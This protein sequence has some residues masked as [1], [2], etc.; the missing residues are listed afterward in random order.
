[1]HI[2]Q[3]G[4]DRASPGRLY[5]VLV[6][7]LLWA[8]PVLAS[9]EG[10]G[11]AIFVIG[12]VTLVPASGPP[13]VL[14]KGHI[15]HVGDRIDT[16]DKGQV[17]IRMIDGAFIAV[18]P[19]S[20]FVVKRYKMD[21]DPQKSESQFELIKGGF[22]AITGKIGKTNKKSYKVVTP[23]AT[24]GIRG[25]DYVAMYCDQDCDQRDHRE[26]KEVVRDGLY[27]G[28]V[29]G[30]IHV[31]N[32]VATIDVHRSQYAYIENRR[33]EPRHL[34]QMPSFLM[35]Q[36]ESPE[37][38]DLA[39]Y[40]HRNEASL[41]DEEEHEH[42]HVAMGREHNRDENIYDHYWEYV[43]G[44]SLSQQHF[45]TRDNF[46]YAL[47]NSTSISFE[48]V[49]LGDMQVRLADLGG[50][51]GVV[52]LL[53]TGTASEYDLGTDP[54]TGLTWGRWAGGTVVVYD[55]VTGEISSVDLG[56]DSLHWIA[57]GDPGELIVLPTT[58]T[59][60]YVL[61]GNTSP[62]DNHG[63][64]GN[65]ADV[66]A[67]LAADFTAQTMDAQ[68]SV[69]INNQVWTATGTGMAI[70]TVNATFAG[71]LNVDVTDS[72]TMNTAI[73]SGTMNGAF[74]G[75]SPTGGAP[76]NVGAAYSMNSDI[77]GVA[78]TVSGVGAFELA[79]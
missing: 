74:S 26:N 67:S 31:T 70:D 49:P 77:N 2:L 71:G 78:T 35:F 51:T 27:V 66:S 4:K 79:P 46:V 40:E 42:E 12:Q 23:V 50:Q 38:S 20:S 73:G 44:V 57:G 17:Q 29:S 34:D 47:G 61:V 72:T 21:T 36:T 63:N 76:T 9:A 7:C 64:V 45:A 24:I 30:G 41:P 11:K 10:V 60:S 8:V 1:M 53:G 59:A 37:D 14:K 58:G 56:S 3:I 52:G 16:S 75:P 22:R 18:R 48:T 6:L 43:Y 33:G 65:A 69:G 32:D 15:L 54:A 28:V 5:L 55:P 39:K 62:T 13:V 19:G 25:T 68:L